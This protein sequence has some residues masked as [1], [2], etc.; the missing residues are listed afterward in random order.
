MKKIILSLAVASLIFASCSKETT[1]S[2]VI[3]NPG[4]IGFNP[5]TGKT[6]RATPSLIG[7][8][9]S[10]PAGFGVYATKSDGESTP[11]QEQ[12][13]ANQAYIYNNGTSKWEW[14]GSANMWPNDA[15]EY[16]IN[17]YAYHPKTETTLALATLS[18]QYEIA[19]NT[20]AAPQKDLL[21]AQKLNVQTRPQSSNVNL[22]F[23]HIL[24]QVKFNVVGG[25][26]MTVEVQ[27]IA[28]KSV[29]SVHT[30]KYGTNPMAWDGTAPATNIDYSYM[31]APAIVANEWDGDGSTANPVTGTS[32]SLMLI[33]QDF[34]ARAW[35]KQAA[36]VAADTYIEVVYRMI[37]TTGGKD[38][39]GYTDADNYPDAA[40]TYSD[41]E[42]NVGKH[43]FVKVGYPL[44][45]VWEMGKTYTYTIYLG[46][47]S[48]S[49]G[50]LTNGFFIDE[51]G[52]TTDLPVIHPDDETQI[53][54]PDPIVDTTQPIDFLVSVGAWDETTPGISLQ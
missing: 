22:D 51:N 14:D 50:N 18:Q 23:K 41:D 52:T 42:A 46:T 32:G 54:V 29:G 13:I 26:G 6:T 20:L 45:T 31:S 2:E 10:D 49:G 53:N 36:P 43:L 1:T 37:E 27:S 48:A 15:A 16:P 33:P 47:P 3:G 21:A 44:P 34:S 38:V 39:V 4:A 12:F 28:V 11:A 30:F 35:D 24:S 19:Q 25:T 40:G 8:L 9:T 17:F 5:S 7:T